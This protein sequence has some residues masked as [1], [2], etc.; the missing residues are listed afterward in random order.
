MNNENN[1]NLNNIPTAP[2]V[3]S[4]PT[5][6]VNQVPTPVND[7]VPTTVVNQVPTQVYGPVSTAAV[8]QVPTPVPATVPT[9]VV[10]QVP[11]QVNVPVQTEIEILQPVANTVQTQ[12]VSTPQQVFINSQVSTEPVTTPPIVGQA[13]VDPNGMINENLKKVEIKDY[14]PPSKLKV[15][16]LLLFFILLIAFIVFLPQISSMIRIYMSGANNPQP[17]EEVI[18]SGKLVCSMT[19][20][21]MDLDKEYKF[22]FEFTDSKLKTTKYVSNIIGDSTAENSLDI[23]AEKCNNLKENASELEGVSIRCNYTGNNL[24]ESQY[25]ELETLDTEKVNAAFTEAGG[26]LPSYKIDQD[27]D[28]IEKNMKASNYTC[29]RQK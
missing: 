19:N 20:N 9:T 11:S 25:F 27:I 16:G 13:Q 12:T 21:S 10:N 7:T 28:E 14:T 26:I 18:T 2:V 24:V 6:M 29:Q 8:N 15:F 5:N 22:T 1:N 4:I 23:L 3:G 17:I